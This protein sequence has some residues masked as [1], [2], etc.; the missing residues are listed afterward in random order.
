MITNQGG[1]EEVLR[2]HTMARSAAVKLTKIW[3]DTYITITTERRL[4]CALIFSIATWTVKNT[5]ANKINAFVMQVYCKM[6][7]GEEVLKDFSILILRNLSVIKIHLSL[8]IVKISVIA[9]I[10]ICTK[11]ST[12]GRHKRQRLWNSFC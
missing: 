11:Q 2:P 3:K 12:K 8:V 7:C 9:Y 5:D 1:Y 4:E 6:D 10:P